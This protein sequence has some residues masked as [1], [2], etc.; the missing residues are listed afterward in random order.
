MCPVP[1]SLCGKNQMECGFY[2]IVSTQLS[3]M[4]HHSGQH[5]L[6]IYFDQFDVCSLS[7]TK[8]YIHYL[9]KPVVITLASEQSHESH[10]AQQNIV[11]I[12]GKYEIFL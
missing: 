11:S 10:Y 8:T 4:H 12:N 7:K 9:L 2:G 6:W 5:L 3:N 1:S